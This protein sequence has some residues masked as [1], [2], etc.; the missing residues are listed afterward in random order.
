METEPFEYDPFS[1]SAMRDPYP[2]YRRLR[3][4]APVY[5]LEQYDGW[6]LSRFQDVWDVFLDR[7]HFTESEGQ[8]FP[9][10][11]VST[12]HHGAQ[13][14]RATADPLSMFNLLDPP[15]QTH[16]R[17]IMAGPLHPAAIARIEPFVRD[18]TRRTLDTLVARGGFD[19]N[20]DFAS[21]ISCS[22][23]SHVIGL[24][25]PDV[26]SMVRLVNRI[27]A[28]APG[29]SGMTEEGW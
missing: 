4:E 26:P 24:R 6:A 13:P 11:V 21:V 14:P 8:V 7:D 9:K 28:R 27:N 16:L 23:I 18:L 17:R 1:D 2:L 29:R 15:I 22:A 10:Q 5:R 25:V 3:A 19:V 20:T 12:S